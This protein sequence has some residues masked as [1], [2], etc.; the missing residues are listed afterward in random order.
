MLNFGFKS[1]GGLPLPLVPVVARSNIR[2]DAPDG[3]LVTWD[4]PMMMSCDI[5]D[6]ISVVIDGAAAIHPT[7]IEFHPHNLAKMGIVMAVPFT[8][9]QVV[10]W[11]YNDSGSCDLQEIAAPNTEADNQTYA[12]NNALPV[13]NDTTFSRADVHSDG[14][15]VVV[16]LSDDTTA[17]SV[18]DEWELTVNGVKL[19]GHAKLSVSG[20]GTRFFDIE[21]HDPAEYI[22]AGDTVLVSHLVADSGIVKFIDQ[23]A[24]NALQAPFITTWKTT[25]ADEPITLPADGTN[26]FT[27]NWGDGTPVETVTTMNPSHIY[28]I[29]GDY[30]VSIVGAA[31][32]WSMS[33]PMKDKIVDIKQWGAIKFK[34][35][36]SG[37]SGCSNL[38]IS[39]TDKPDLSTCTAMRAVFKDCTS[40][41][42][43]DLSGCDISLAT[44]MDNMF[45]GCTELISCNLSGV[46]AAPT[47]ALSTMFT[48]CAKLQTLDFRGFDV[49]AITAW[50]NAF[51]GCTTLT[52]IKGIETF[53]MSSVTRIQGF[54]QNCTSMVSFPI[55]GW[56]MSSMT[57]PYSFASGCHI[58]IAEYDAI[59]LAWSQQTVKPLTHPIHFG[60]A[61]KYSASSQAARDILTSAPNNWNIIDGGVDASTVKAT[62]TPTPAPA[63]EGTQY[64]TADGQPFVTSDNEKFRVKL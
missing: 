61:T 21:I 18:S 26:N 55:A 31:G 50:I 13:P 62:T 42:H 43:I 19:T 34:S 32:R 49:S 6:Q 46:T 40:L 38:N 15:G 25:A 58:P 27:V 11:S 44:I 16:T 54:F 64:K 45:S 52:E 47:M 28:A 37:F 20:H 5:K 57:A 56:D 29:P 1:S 39:A 53:D 60:T 48:G 63:P 36:Y 7:S 17:A 9:G 4:R 3:I 51:K 33:V 41:T 2:A 59:L 14:H 35:L 30:D 10:T 8:P 22:V 23:P 24:D 12:V